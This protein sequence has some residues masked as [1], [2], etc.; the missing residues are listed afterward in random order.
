MTQADLFNTPSPTELQYA[1]YMS[2]LVASE[3]AYRIDNGIVPPWVESDFLVSKD[4]RRLLTLIAD[5]AGYMMR[6]DDYVI[7]QYGDTGAR[8]VSR[9]TVDMLMNSEANSK[10]VMNAAIDRGLITITRVNDMR[11]NRLDLTIRGR[12]YLD[13]CETNDYWESEESE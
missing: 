3:E 9:F 7:T 8:S 11:A 2:E 10:A 5:H 13:L 6:D 1:A 12:Y 4:K